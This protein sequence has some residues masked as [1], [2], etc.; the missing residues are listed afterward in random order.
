MDLLLNNLPKRFRTVS[1]INV[2]DLDKS[3]IISECKQRGLFGHRLNI[4]NTNT[5]KELYF[6]KDLSIFIINNIITNVSLESYHLEPLEND[7]VII[8]KETDKDFNYYNELFHLDSFS[9]KNIKYIVYD[10]E[11]VFKNYSLI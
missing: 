7:L 10:N 11:N 4:I 6:K 3:F 1:E 8:R 5:F 2:T 9:E